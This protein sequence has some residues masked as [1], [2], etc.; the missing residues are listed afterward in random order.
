MAVTKLRSNASSHKRTLRAGP[1]RNRV[2]KEYELQYVG[3]NRPFMT[4]EI[5]GK[6]TANNRIV[7]DYT[8]AVLLLLT[9]LSVVSYFK[10]GHSL[11]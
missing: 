6:I 9:S 1:L 5:M 3:S 7:G 2:S 10:G 11:K 8:L 4:T